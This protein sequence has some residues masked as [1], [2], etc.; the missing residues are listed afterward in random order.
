[1]TSD[2]DLLE[3]WRAG[4]RNAGGELFDRYFDPV[5]RFFLNKIDEDVEDLVQQT[6]LACATARDRIQDASGFRGYVFATARSKLIDRLRGRS[7]RVDPLDPERDSVAALGVTPTGALGATEDQD[8]LLQALRHLPLDLQIA[9][10]LYY[11]EDI[12]GSALVTALGLQ[13][14]TVR[15]RLRRG[16][17]RLRAQIDLLIASPHLRKQTLTTLDTWASRLRDQW[18]EQTQ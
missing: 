17:E 16:I 4:D 15:S 3:A 8:L 18:K 11:F 10:E 5:R 14:G 1:M 6:F 2:E 7:K 12:R 9:L 13:P